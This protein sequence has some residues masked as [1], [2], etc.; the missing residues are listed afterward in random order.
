MVEFVMVMENIVHVFVS[1]IYQ[2]HRYGLSHGMQV[3]T[4]LQRNSEGGVVFFNQQKDVGEGL[5]ATFALE[6]EIWEGIL[7]VSLASWLFR[8]FSFLGGLMWDHLSPNL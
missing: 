1:L 4:A 8:C 5:D 3:P 2:V 7:C 6:A